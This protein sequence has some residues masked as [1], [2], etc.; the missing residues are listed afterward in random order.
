MKILPT[1]ALQLAVDGV[2]GVAVAVRQVPG[3]CDL[4]CCWQLLG[5]VHGHEALQLCRVQGW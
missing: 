5:R 4:C 1:V 2:G 3:R